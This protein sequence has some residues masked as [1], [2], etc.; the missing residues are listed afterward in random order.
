[1]LFY[2]KGR[3]KMIQ[4]ISWKMKA[5]SAMVLAALLSACGSGGS[6]SNGSE[7]LDIGLHNGSGSQN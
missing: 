7:R 5:V 6:G 1:M 2:V 4:S 3:A